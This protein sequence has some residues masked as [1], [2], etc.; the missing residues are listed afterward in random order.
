MI[1]PLENNPGGISMSIEKKFSE[2]L[3]SE[4]ERYLKLAKEHADVVI[5]DVNVGQVVGGMR[6]VKSLLTD[7]SFV[8]P[9][10]GIRFRGMTIPEVLDALPKPVGAAMPYVGGLF[11]LLLIGEV[12]TKEQALEIEAE[13]AKRSD[14]P[15]H[16]YDSLRAM[17][18]DTH[19]MTLFSM[20]V[21]S[22]QTQSEFSRRYHE[23]MQKTEY[24][25]PALED[26]LNLTAKLPVVAAFIFN[27][28]YRDGQEPKID[29]NLDYGANF[30][31]LVGI[32]DQ[33]GYADLS[34]LYTIIHSD[35]ESGNASAHATHLAA[36]TLSDV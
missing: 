31:Q 25:K 22:L 7:I 15:G 33:K 2:Q 36:S 16:V 35:H 20:A 32:E 34:R 6:G 14:V 19:P 28:K 8:D 24:W 17:P 21:L 18:K 3:P 4:R 10:E 29:P 13:W 27:L 30:A 5:A 9:A 12:P 11:Y 23:G 1:L 26:A